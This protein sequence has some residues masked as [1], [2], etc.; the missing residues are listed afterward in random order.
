MGNAPSGKTDVGEC[1]SKLE[2]TVSIESRKS[3]ARFEFLTLNSLMMFTI[4]T[5]AIYHSIFY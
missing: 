4:Y 3:H 2:A 5:F 1:V